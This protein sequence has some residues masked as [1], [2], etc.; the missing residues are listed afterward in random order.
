VQAAESGLQYLAIAADDA[1]EIRNWQA[2]SAYPVVTKLLPRN[3]DGDHLAFSPALIAEAFTVSG[4][5]LI[6]EAVAGAPQPEHDNWQQGFYPPLDLTKENAACE[7]QDQTATRLSTDLAKVTNKQHD[8][9]WKYHIE[10]SNPTGCLMMPYSDNQP[11][12]VPHSQLYR[13]HLDANEKARL[14]KVFCKT[15]KP[16]DAISVSVNGQKYDPVW[17]VD[18]S[19]VNYAAQLAPRTPLVIS[20][21]DSR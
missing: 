1:Q 17:L 7:R 13:F 3:C 11:I 21:G 4:S 20:V 19:G 10:V 8:T 18:D 9:R 16:A 12:P 6:R 15:E 14:E 5:Y 2:M